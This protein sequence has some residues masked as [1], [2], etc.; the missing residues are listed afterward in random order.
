MQRSIP[1]SSDPFTDTNFLARLQQVLQTF[2]GRNQWHILRVSMVAVDAALLALAFLLA[3]RMRFEWG[4]HLFQMDGMND[5]DYYRILAA[6]M[7]PLWLGVLALQGGYLRRNILGGTREYELIFQ[8][9][10][11]GLVLIL[12][13]N[14]LDLTFVLSRGWLF[15]AGVFGMG[16]WAL[17]RFA[18][19]RLVYRLRLAGYFVA[20]AIIVGANEEGRL[21]A[22]Q[23]RRWR[24]SGLYVVGFVDKRFPAGTHITQEAVSLGS[25]EELDEIIRKYDI[26][27][28]VLASSAFSARDN[29]VNIFRNYM[30]ADNVEIRLSSGLYE[31]FTTGLTVM[32][33]GFVP[34]VGVNKMRL[35]GMDAILK[36]ALDYGI[37]VPGFIAILP[38]FLGL[39]LA[40]RLTSPGPI[41]HR[42]RVMGMNGK[43]FDAFKFRSMYVDGDARLTSADKAELLRTQKL[44]QDPRLTPIGA[45]IRRFSLDEL[46]QL[47]NVLRGEMSLVGPR[48]ISPAEMPKYAQWSQNLLT[49]RPGLTGLWQ[50]SGRSDVSYEDRV[51][52]DMY[53]I[54]NWT[55]WLDLQ[56]LFQTPG[57]VVR[58]RG[59]Y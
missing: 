4:A 43:A 52:L 30:H 5:L 46:P 42:R 40:V 12:L 24:T 3:Y 8:T 9:T 55:I 13:Y 53:Y 27:V 21:L 56:I 35:T 14:F 11:L 34:L 7:V 2:V 22:D 37:T 15:L 33:S 31:I 25:V 1:M 45:F 20:P 41:F 10:L 38:I 17:G 48:M 36:R 19:R 39:A 16:L 18:I 44:K 49:V 50:V 59:A 58:G 54:R 47:L 23:L 26:Q 6:L 51:R 28:V 57:V 29:M 32:E